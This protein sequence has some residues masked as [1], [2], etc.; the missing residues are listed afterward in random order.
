M[1]TNTSSF[2]HGTR[3]CYNDKGRWQRQKNKRSRQGSFLYINCRRS[4]LA[5]VIWDG[6]RKKCYVQV[7]MLE[8]LP[9]TGS[10]KEEHF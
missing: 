9:T 2:V 3:V 5:A 10:D 4:W 6:R 7:E 1:D 8:A